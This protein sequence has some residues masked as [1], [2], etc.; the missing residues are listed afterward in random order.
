M[1]RQWK[2][3]G[4]ENITGR[5]RMKITIT[6]MAIIKD[7]ENLTWISI[8]MTFS[9]HCKCDSSICAK[10]PTAFAWSNEDAQGNFHCQATVKSRFPLS[11]TAPGPKES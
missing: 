3:L 8:A 9:N 2:V 7:N 5:K 4:D 1:A 10:T 11:S 6:R